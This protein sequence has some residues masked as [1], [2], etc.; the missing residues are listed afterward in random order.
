MASDPEGVHRTVEGRRRAM[1]AA[2]VLLVV[3]ALF[4]PAAYWAAASRVPPFT[5]D[6]PPTPTPNG[7]VVAR[8]AVPAKE[9]TAHSGLQLL[10]TCSVGFR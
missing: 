2:T 3:A 9:R 8:K 10:F 5:R 7:Y 1:A 6:L 4:L